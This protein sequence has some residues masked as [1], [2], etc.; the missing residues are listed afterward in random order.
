MK[1]LFKVFG[2]I[3]LVAII[4]FSFAACGGD[5]GDGGGGGGGGNGFTITDIP[6][7]YNGKYADFY[8]DSLGVSYSEQYSVIRGYANDPSDGSTK[9]VLISNGKV[10][11]PL[12]ARRKDNASK[13]DKFS[14]NDSFGGI[15]CTIYNDPNCQDKFTDKGMFSTVKFSN[16][17]ATKS[18]ND[19]LF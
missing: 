9:G 12:W 7:E 4:G 8:T 11:I 6:A 5:D 18:W 3:A 14:G 13:Y 1:N 15:I 10:S 16:G 17:N 19:F 2:I